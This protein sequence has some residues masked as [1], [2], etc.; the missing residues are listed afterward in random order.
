MQK[1]YLSIKE[2]SEYINIPVGT[3]YVWV[4]Q[5]RIPHV[6]FSRLVRFDLKAIDEWVGEKNVEV[7]KWWKE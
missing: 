1:R 5:K 7:A 2:L 3:L 6:K 4:W